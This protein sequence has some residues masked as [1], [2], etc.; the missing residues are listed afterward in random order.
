M[1]ARD[2]TDDEVAQRA[3]EAARLT[4]PDADVDTIRRLEGGVSSLTY[5]AR[6]RAEGTAQH[7]VLKFAPPGLEPVRNRDVLRQA[8]VLDSLAGLDGF[9]VPRVLVRDAG[10][11]PEVPPMFAME[12]RPGQAYEP[13][14]DVS[15]EPPSA[16][17]AAAREHELTRALALLQSRTPAQLGL[18]DEPVHG[19]AH[20]LDRWRTL[21]ATVDADIGVGH[22]D[23]AMRLAERIPRDIAP[24]LVHGDYRAANALFVG[25]R[26]EAVIDWEIWSVGD[27]RPDLAWVLMH[28]SPSHVFHP[29]RSAD[30]L[31]AGRL[32]PS[33][34]ELRTTY[35]HAR[36]SHGAAPL[37]VDDATRDLDWFLGVAHFKVAA[38][39]AVIWKR[40][41][42]RDTP[43]PK[44]VV[45]AEGLDRV[46]AAGHR[47]LDVG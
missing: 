29:D 13:L 4:W 24:R 8:R 47:A 28:T 7:V 38:T 2:I 9:P 16:R 17:E 40:E 35:V 37:D 46:L 25:P 12:L 26:L 20:E 44:L 19:A 1:P 41:R 43:D 30:D 36:M 15:D 34:D 32:M 39:I 18:E 6:L 33:V 5:A 42:K 45:A 14:L 27:P 22:D 21:F 10:Q 3:T 31:E 11:P 23:L